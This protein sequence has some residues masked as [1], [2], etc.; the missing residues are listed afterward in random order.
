MIEASI[1]PVSHDRYS[2]IRTLWAKVIQRAAY[3][4]VTYREHPKLSMRK[5]AEQAY[6]WI[7]EPSAM[8]NSFN[9]ACRYAGRNPEQVRDRIR[10]M[11]KE[12]VSKAEYTDRISVRAYERERRALRGAV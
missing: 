4:W 10:H 9:N 5:L 12:D 2:G 11:T 1:E 6:T 7:F 8:F 3:D